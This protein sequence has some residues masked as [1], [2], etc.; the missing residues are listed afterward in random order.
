M[1]WHCVKVMAVVVFPD[2]GGLFDG[3][4]SIWR[5]RCRG[6]Y[7][8]VKLVRLNIGYAA[9]DICINQN[10]LEVRRIDAEMCRR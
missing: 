1:K 4:H 3:D 2:A 9:G 10:M 7:G 8:V 5:V 6:G